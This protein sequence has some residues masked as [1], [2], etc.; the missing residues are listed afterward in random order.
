MVKQIRKKFW[1]FRESISG[2]PVHQRHRLL[3]WSWTTTHIPEKFIYDDEAHLLQVVN[4]FIADNKILDII[5][6]KD[7]AGMQSYCDYDN[8]WSDRVGGIELVYTV[9]IPD[10]RTP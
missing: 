7:T 8:V 1:S 9:A 3:F 4:D 2:D 6:F 5:S 10:A